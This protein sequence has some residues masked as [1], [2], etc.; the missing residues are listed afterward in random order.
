MNRRGVIRRLQKEGWMFVYDALHSVLRDISEAAPEKSIMDILG[1]G[2]QNVHMSSAPTLCR[3]DHWLLAV[4][5]SITPFHPHAPSHI[6]PPLYISNLSQYTHTHTHT[7][8]KPTHFGHSH[9]RTQIAYGQG[10]RCMQS[11]WKID[12]C[13]RNDRTNFWVQA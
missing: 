11:Y 4:P 10:K 5:L 12:C 7:H 8:I 3:Y 1:N 13:S 6:I 9:P 2:N